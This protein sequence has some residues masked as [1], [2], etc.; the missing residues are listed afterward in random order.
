MGTST[1]ARPPARSRSRLSSQLNY[2]V[3]VIVTN[4]S[5]QAWNAATTILRYRWYLAGSTTSFSDSGSLYG[6][7]AFLGLA[8]AFA[9]WRAGHRRPP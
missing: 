4:T 9:W 8:S 5:G 7:A 1:P 3:N 6:V 2:P